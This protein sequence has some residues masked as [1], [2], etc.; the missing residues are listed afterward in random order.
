VLDSATAH[1]SYDLLACAGDASRSPS[2]RMLAIQLLNQRMTSPKATC[3]SHSEQL[4]FGQI[5]TASLPR[6]D[7]N[8]LYAYGSNIVKT[9]CQCDLA[10]AERALRQGFDDSGSLQATLLRELRRV[11]RRGQARQQWLEQVRG[12]VTARVDAG[13]FIEGDLGQEWMKLD[14]DGCESYLAQLTMSA[15][16]VKTRH[17]I[18]AIV[19]MRDTPTAHRILDDIIAL[20]E[21]P[22]KVALA[23]RERGSGKR[24]RAAEAAAA[25]EW[26]TTRSAASLKRLYFDFIER[27]EEGTKF[28]RWMTLLGAEGIREAY[29]F[30]SADGNASLF[31][32]VDGKGRLRGSRF[33]G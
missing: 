9:W 24:H 18:P 11:S 6:G 7:E 20:G 23:L 19:E 16:T 4:R 30:R 32:D 10:G 33:E 25:K 1:H 28:D 8:S 27:L 22:A 31:V 13:E 15:C 2:E 3:L 5:L 17:S 12:M 21:W 26:R 29:G 14:P